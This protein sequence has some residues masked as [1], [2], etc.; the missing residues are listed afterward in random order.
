MII[1]YVTE[2]YYRI[3]FLCRSERSYNTTKYDYKMYY[4]TLILSAA[5]LIFKKKPFNRLNMIV[6]Y[7]QAY[8]NL[9]NTFRK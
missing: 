2:N 9:L 7:D 4:R 1:K 8:L 6:I 3:L 5:T